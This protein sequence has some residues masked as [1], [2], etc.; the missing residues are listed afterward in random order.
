[1]QS[2]VPKPDTAHLDDVLV[3][4]ADVRDS[5]E[6][7]AFLRL[8]NLRDFEPALS[9]V[10]RAQLLDAVAAATARCWAARTYCGSGEC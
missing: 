10:D 7:E 4:L 2:A 6:L 3:A 1:M 8:L 5:V 9:E